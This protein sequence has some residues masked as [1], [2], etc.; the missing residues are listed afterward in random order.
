MVKPDQ[1][2]DDQSESISLK[3]KGQDG[4]EM[5]FRIKRSTVMKKLL[6]TYC[7]RKF[8]N[9]K[10]VRFLINGERFDPDKNPTDLGLS[11]GDEID[12]MM[13]QAGGSSEIL[14]HLRGS[15]YYP[16]FY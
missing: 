3:V 11:D 9:Y 5:F 8:L 12:A 13:D 14:A 10:S 2:D 16:P 1:R 4:V 7:D 6:K 15:S